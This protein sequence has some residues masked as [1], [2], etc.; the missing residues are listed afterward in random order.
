MFSDEWLQLMMNILI[1]VTQHVK[2]INGFHIFIVMSE[3]KMTAQ[4]S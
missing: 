3:L 4:S 2:L 1:Y